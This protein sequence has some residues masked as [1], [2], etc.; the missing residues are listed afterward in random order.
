MVLPVC[1]YGHPV[2]RDVAEDITPDY[3]KLAEIISNMW[4]TMYDSEGIGIAAPQV[5]ISAPILV[6][7]VDVMKDS[8][9]ELA[10][11]KLTMINP[12]VE[13]VEDGEVK[14]REEGCLSLPGI[15]ESVTRTEKVKVEWV[16]ENFTPQSAEFSGYLARVIQHENDHLQGMV[17]IDHISPIRKQLIRS[18]LKNI[19]DGKVRCSYRT[20]SASLKR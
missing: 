17:F 6:I 14:S 1:L 12:I 9:P 19:V 2:L 5:G 3:P 11:V 4:D 15:H 16:D 10:G 8:F 18:K 13:V 20:R 7:D